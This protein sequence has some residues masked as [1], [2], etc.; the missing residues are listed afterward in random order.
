VATLWRAAAF[1]RLR[2]VAVCSILAAGTAGPHFRP[3]V[4]ELVLDLPT[5]PTRS[6]D[7]D[8]VTRIS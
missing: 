1:R 8:K 7:A 4:G 3:A 6:L 5:A 2:A